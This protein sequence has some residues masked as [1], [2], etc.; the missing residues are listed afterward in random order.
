MFQKNFKASIQN[1][2]ERPLR[3][4]RDGKKYSSKNIENQCQNIL[5]NDL[6]DGV[7]Q[8]FKIV[9]KYMIK[10][11]KTIKNKKKNKRQKRR[12][13][14]MRGIIRDVGTSAAI[15]WGISYFVKPTVVHETSMQPSI[16]PNDRVLLSRRA[17]KFKDIKRGNVIVVKAKPLNEDDSK[18]LFKRRKLF[19]KRVIGVSGDVITVTDGVVRVNGNIPK[20]DYLA[21][22]Y[23]PGEIHNLIV[24][25]NHVFVMGDNR[26]VSKDSRQVGCFK[27]KD[28][29]G[30][31]VFK[32]SPLKD[33]GRIKNKTEK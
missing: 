24:P 15:A 27:S 12:R 20:E 6:K 19:I 21:D 25:E 1:A 10:L 8:D 28:I 7:S 5:S 11:R 17:Y 14:I 31:A 4:L 33:L 13:K 30:K 3:L 23:T 9:S 26:S 32:I 18:S 29:V 2:F 22:E 16:N